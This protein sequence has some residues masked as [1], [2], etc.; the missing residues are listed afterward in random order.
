MAIIG[1][2]VPISARQTRVTLQ[3]PGPAVSNGTGGYTQTWVDLP[4]SV[5]AEVA[6]ASAHSLERVAAGTV[7]VSATHEVTIPY[8]AGVSNRTR[9][10]LNGRHLNVTSVVDKDERHV[11]LVLICEEVL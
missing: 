10:L 7:I 1:P 3:N 4:P 8:R 6:P 9:V 2:T 5:D 11:E